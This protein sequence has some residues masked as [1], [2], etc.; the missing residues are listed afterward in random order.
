MRQR[1]R[2]NTIRSSLQFMGKYVSLHGVTKVPYVRLSKLISLSKM[3]WHAFLTTVYLLHDYDY[4]PDDPMVCLCLAIASVGRAMQRQ[5]LLYSYAVKHY[6]KVLELAEMVES[7]VS[8]FCYI[9]L[10]TDLYIA[11][12]HFSPRG[13]P[14]SLFGIYTNGGCSV[15]GSVIPLLAFHLIVLGNAVYIILRSK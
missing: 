14:Q 6:E 15:S 13:G 12:A 5:S 1:Y 8:V 7:V 10:S 4:C 2:Q 9:E 3:T 11:G